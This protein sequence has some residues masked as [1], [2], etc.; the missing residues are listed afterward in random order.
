VP[1]FANFA[2]VVLPVLVDV[3]QKIATIF[4]KSLVPA[5]RDFV[6]FANTKVI[7][8]VKRVADVFSAFLGFLAEHGGAVKT[9]AEVTMG[10]L[11]ARFAALKIK[12]A[13]DGIT[14]FVGTLKAN[15]ASVRTF[16]AQVFSVGKNVI[17]TAINIGR[18]TAA[19][20]ASKVAMLAAAAAQKILT[21][22]QW[23]LNAAM[24]ANPIGLIVVGVAALVAG[25]IL[26]YQKFKPFRAIVDAVG[27]AIATAAG[28]IKNAAV[29]AFNWIKDHWPLL[30]AILSGPIG[31]AVLAITKN[32]DAITG[33][34]RAVWSAVKDTFDRVVGFVTGLPGRIA[35]AAAGMWDGITE[36]FRSAVNFLIDIWNNLHFGA[37]VSAFGH[38]IGFDLNT[39]DL[40]HLAGGGVIT[41]PTLAF[42]GETSRARPEIAAPAPLISKIVG[43]ELA[44][45]PS[46]QFVVNN[47]QGATVDDILRALRRVQ[48]LANF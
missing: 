46:Q 17:T 32:W 4:A 42:L 20:V 2:R 13:V 11:V 35:S 5:F 1:L 44:K 16:A 36:A 10:L 24:D 43:D 39:P 47:T 23:L 6:D 41:S 15:I 18:Q 22:A 21:A 37:H 28:V 8:I 34:A 19:F 33:G 3:G 9:F 12:A 29:G 25:V 30:L 26:A 38:T 31:L 40:P 48:M 7:P 45:R 27:R 14:R